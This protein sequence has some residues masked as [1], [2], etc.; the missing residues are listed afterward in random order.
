MFGLEIKQKVYNPSIAFAGQIEAKS[1]LL[2]DEADR[3]LLDHAIWINHDNVI[4][5][6]ATSFTQDYVVE[7]EYIESLF[8][9]LDS[10]IEGT[11]DHLNATIDVTLEEF[12]KKSTGFAKI[13]FNTDKSF[14]CE[15]TTLNDCENLAR[16]K[17]LTN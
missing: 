16:L 10:M 17:T 13:I 3:I 15:G 1:F 9:C 12:L 4:A 8:T 2:I 11:I 7:K 14:K 6:S 5:L